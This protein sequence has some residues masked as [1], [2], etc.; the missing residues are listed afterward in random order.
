MRVAQTMLNRAQKEKSAL[1]E[2]LDVARS[3]GQDAEHL[4]AKLA[5]LEDEFTEVS[6]AMILDLSMAYMSFVSSLSVTTIFEP[7]MP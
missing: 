6:D 3:Q 1:Q 4:K 7:S 2:E 5:Q